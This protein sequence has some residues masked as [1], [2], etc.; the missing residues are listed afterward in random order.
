V[1]AV[2][3]A[4]QKPNKKREKST[5]IKEIYADRGKHTKE[6]IIKNEEREK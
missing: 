3:I 5:R 1:A 6:D 4:S 2:P